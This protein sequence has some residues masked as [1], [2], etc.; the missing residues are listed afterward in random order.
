MLRAT[1]STLASTKGWRYRW[2]PKEVRGVLSEALKKVITIDEF[3]A[4]MEKLTY[5]SL[6]IDPRTYSS[7]WT[8]YE[9]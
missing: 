8:E 5:A 1:R 9:G 3:R 4:W 2:P 6:Y 7:F